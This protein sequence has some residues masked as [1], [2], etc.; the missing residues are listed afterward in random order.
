M[1][2]SVLTPLQLDAG[3]GLLQ[4]QGLAPNV[5]FAS[6]TYAY[7]GNY[8]GTGNLAPQTAVTGLLAAIRIGGSNVGNGTILSNAVIANLQTLA[9]NS[10]PALSDS[11]PASYSGNITV[12]VN[13]PGFSGVLTNSAN[14]YL[15]NGDLTKFVQGFNIAES[16]TTQT[17]LFVNTAVNSQTYLGNTFSNMN[18]MITGDITTVNL[19]TTAFGTD[20]EALGVLWNLADLESLGSPFNLI[21]RIVSLTGNLPV[22]GLLLLAEGVSEDTVF[23]LTNPTL[24]VTDSEQR[25]MYQAMTKTTGDNLAQIL[26][27]LKI[28]TAG[29]DTM[30]D[31]LN[32]VRLFPNSFQSLTVATAGGSRAIYVNA[33]GAIN[34][35]LL[36]ELPAYVISSYNQLQQIIPPDQA[37]ANKALSSALKQIT[38]ISFLSLPDFALTVKGMQTTKDLPLISAL[39]QAVPP[40][41][42]NYYINTL[43]DGTGPGNTILI[44]DVLGTAIGWISTDAL[45]NTVAIFNTMNLTYLKTIYQTMTN[46]V[47]GQYDSGNTVVIPSGTPGTGSYTDINSAFT[48]ESAGNVVAGGPG[49]IPTA[50]A[51]L[52]NVVAA[53]PT[54]VTSLNQNWTNM[55]NQVILE[56]SLQ[57]SAQLNYA[58]LTANQQ[59]SMYGFIFSLPGYG[60]DT[61]VGGT[62]QFIEGI[63]QLDTFTGQ[64]V[65]ACLRQGRNQVLLSGS[66]IYTNSSIPA[67]PAEPPPQA[68]LLPSVYSENEAGNLV[69]K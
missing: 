19:A 50:L 31:L 12:Y 39:D 29:I 42:A 52:S 54:Q 32:P 17:N 65:V 1:A 45:G 49:L 68:N 47:N 51:E 4:N 56:Q 34:T 20:L 5:A 14:T 7:T 40:Q 60:T 63:A 21:N 62:A 23:N 61:A 38:G 46:A 55:A 59:N 43:A 57:A 27:V 13:P 3:A 33:S 69:V 44:T 11:V 41:V 9:A 30:A 48:G 16:Y 66:G 53:Y 22:L 37:L 18:N 8:G 58:N 2:I 64:A 28:T 67:E 25:L 15:G 6:A 24:S 35:A 26:K 10:C 36:T